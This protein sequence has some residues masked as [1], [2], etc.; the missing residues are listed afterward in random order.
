L[1]DVTVNFEPLI[2]NRG[3]NTGVVVISLE[4][5]NSLNASQHELSSQKNEIR[6]DTAIEKLKQGNTLSKTLI[7]D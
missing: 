7:Q 1:D 4:E 6:L 2:I 3:K 5:Y